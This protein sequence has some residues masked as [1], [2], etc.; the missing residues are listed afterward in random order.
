MKTTNSYSDFSSRNLYDA[1]L[2][3]TSKRH[4][5]EVEHKIN[6]MMETCKLIL[7]T[8]IP[9]NNLVFELKF[10]LASTSYENWT[11]F[12]TRTDYVSAMMCVT[13][14]VPNTWFQTEIFPPPNHYSTPRRVFFLIFLRTIRL[15]AAI[16][17]L[18]KTTGQRICSKVLSLTVAWFM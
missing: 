13:T 2:K 12:S 16:T 18:Y 17:F 9:K 6:R 4:E 8:C 15:S 14:D 10:C 7:V 1:K 3:F 11:N 5:S